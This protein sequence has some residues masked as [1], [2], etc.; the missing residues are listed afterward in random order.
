V[1]LVFGISALVAVLGSPKAAEYL[2]LVVIVPVA[3]LRVPTMQRGGG[4]RDSPAN[5]AQNPSLRH[6]MILR[7]VAL[8]VLGLT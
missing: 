6:L 4:I 3:L 2:W 8:E 7:L 1:A 5:R